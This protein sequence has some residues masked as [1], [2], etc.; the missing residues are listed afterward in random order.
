MNPDTAEAWDDSLGEYKN[1]C[2]PSKAQFENLVAA[3]E[4]FFP[5]YRSQL[6]LSKAI[7]AGWSVSYV[8]KHTVPLTR[9]PAILIAAHFASFGMPRLGIGLLLQRE[10]GLRPREMLSLATH[11]ISL[12]EHSLASAEYMTIALGSRSGTKAKRAQAVICR[13]RI[14][15]GLY[16]YLHAVTYSGDRLVPYSYEQY[17]RAL[18]RAEQIWGISVGYTPHSPRAGFASEAFAEGMSFSDIKEAGR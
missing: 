13:Q 2:L 11:D 18:K 5:R 8:A 9:A 3:V 16:R 14:L 15:V 4:F 17:R 6:K 1:S 12:P 7:V 10:L